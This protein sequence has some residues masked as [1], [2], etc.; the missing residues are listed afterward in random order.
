VIRTPE[1]R[2]PSDARVRFLP[3]PERPT[4]SVLTNIVIL[5]VAAIHVTILVLQDAPHV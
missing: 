1:A 5:A 3:A 4:A 2:R